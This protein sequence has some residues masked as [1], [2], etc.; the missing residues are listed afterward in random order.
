MHAMVM[1]DL[2]WRAS[3][4]RIELKTL[5]L[6]HEYIHG[7]EHTKHP[8]RILPL[9]MVTLLLPLHDPP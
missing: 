6:A 1:A 5:L 8:L 7:P 2:Y 9:H 3:E 4:Q